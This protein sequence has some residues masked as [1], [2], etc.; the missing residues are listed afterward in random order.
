MRRPELEYPLKIATTTLGVDVWV[1]M[2]NSA[3]A[4][5]NGSDPTVVFIYQRISF[6]YPHE[7]DAQM[8]LI[9]SAF[10]N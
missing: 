9:I 1:V 7:A 6:A 3:A 8:N 10:A 5:A 2:P 4:I